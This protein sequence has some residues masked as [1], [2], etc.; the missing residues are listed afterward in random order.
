MEIHRVATAAPQSQSSVQSEVRKRV[1]GHGLYGHG[2]IT[3]ESSH[4]V[5]EI[6]EHD[7]GGALL[8][9][10]LHSTLTSPAKSG[11]GSRI[12]I[13]RPRRRPLAQ[14]ALDIFLPA[15]Y[16]HSVT[17]D[18]TAYQLYDSGQAFASSIA[19]LLASRA[20]LV[21]VG[22]GDAS[23]SATAALLLNIAQE[24]AGRVATIAFAARLGTALQPECKMWR[25]AAD[26]LNDAAMLLDA[27]SPA[28]PR[29]WRVV[30]LAT[31]SM[32][33]ALCGV[34]AGS[35]KA[36]LSGHFARSGNLGEVSAKDASQ[37]TVVGL[38][39]MLA[40]SIVVSRVQG[41]VAT[42][43]VLVMLLVV[44]LGM[45]WAAVRAVQMNSLN[46]QRAGLVFGGLLA[47][48]AVMGPAEVASRERIWE[49]SGILRHDG[50][51]CIGRCRI[52]VTLEEFV[53]GLA[54]R[55]EASTGAMLRT[56]VSLEEVQRLY[57][58][59]A[60]L[61]CYDA[62]RE[63]VMIVLKADARVVD[64]LKAWYQALLLAT[65]RRE[66]AGGERE[67]ISLTEMTMTLGEADKHWSRHVQLVEEAG[68]DLQIAALET[69]SGTRITLRQ[70][71]AS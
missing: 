71:E 12:D 32:L 65:R 6:D 13:V 30:V 53:R 70:V 8:A 18:Y 48:G 34:A 55:Q 10:Y 38:A 40:G 68:W 69:R 59:E 62:E 56:A 17:S 46:R 26:V 47:N 37:E 49:W 45:N 60:Y 35:A 19:G 51:A 64:Q 25:L 20:V 44:H 33:R 4:L 7:A 39:G 61:L 14:R 23:A 63:C 58:R 16:P 11:T 5:A 42:W 31:A 21:G 1:A 9:T 36:S 29:G 24:S 15:G 43:A 2:S 52:G 22:V 28:V 41:A 3:M 67:P 66:R 54:A 57:A 50:G 27:A